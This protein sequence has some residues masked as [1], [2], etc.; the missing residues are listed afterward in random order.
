MNSF[1]SARGSG[2]GKV[3]CPRLDCWPKSLSLRIPGTR[4]KLC[5]LLA[6][7]LVQQSGGKSMVLARSGANPGVDVDRLFNGFYALLPRSFNDRAD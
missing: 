7:N 3:V 4:R 1:K 6:D 2:S 5:Q